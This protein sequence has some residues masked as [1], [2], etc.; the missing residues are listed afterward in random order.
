M[1]RRALL[2]AAAL[3]LVLAVPALAGPGQGQGHPC[4]M[5]D[6]AG[7]YTRPSQV[8]IGNGPQD[9]LYQLNLA[10]DGT[11]YQEWTGYPELMNTLGTGT[12]NIGSWTCQ[13]GQV[14]LVLITGNFLPVETQD[15]FTGDPEVDITLSSH[16]RVTYRFDVADDD[17]L[18]RNAVVIRSYSPTED[19]TDPNAGTL[20]AVNTN[21]VTYTRLVP[22]DAD[23]NP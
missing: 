14:I 5:K 13:D 22:T 21:Q 8:D 23:L 18:V 7:S 16:S 1:V 17:T 12:P 9:Y 10:A 11:A 6:V 3:S 2:S 19:P 4:K 20:G 15:P